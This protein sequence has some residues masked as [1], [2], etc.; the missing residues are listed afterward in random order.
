MFKG[1]GAVFVI[2]GGGGIPGTEGNYYNM[3]LIFIRVRAYIP[4]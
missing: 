2:A 4:P 3:G 1:V